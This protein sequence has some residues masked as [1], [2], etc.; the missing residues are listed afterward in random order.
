MTSFWKSILT[1]EGRRTLKER[2]GYTASVRRRISI[3]SEF[4]SS[5]IQEIKTLHPDAVFLMSSSGD[6]FLAISA[7]SRIIIEGKFED[8]LVPALAYVDSS[9][10][11][12][13]FQMA[14]ATRD[15]EKRIAS[16]LFERGRIR[17][18]RDFD[19][20]TEKGYS[21][22]AKSLNLAYAVKVSKNGE[23]VAKATFRSPKDRLELTQ[24]TYKEIVERLSTGIFV[25]LRI[26]VAV[27]DD[28]MQSECLWYEFSYYDE[29]R[30]SLSQ[31]K[32]FLVSI[33]QNIIPFLTV[34]VNVLEQPPALSEIEDDDDNAE[35]YALRSAENW[36]NPPPPSERIYDWDADGNFIGDPDHYEYIPEDYQPED[37]EK[38]PPGWKKTTT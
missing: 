32:D 28:Y 11:D 29:A 8:R 14:S 23:D 16:Y 33:C 18:S 19:K 2:A 25:S 15:F 38:A 20:P 24:K 4:R 6:R 17:I 10:S 26:E 5:A 7:T 34:M 22:R 21:Y 27:F 36:M 13:N 1:A 9:D 30:H 12:A 31:N 3:L 37:Y 35:E